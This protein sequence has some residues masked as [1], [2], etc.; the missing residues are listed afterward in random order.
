[1]E[2]RPATKAEFGDWSRAA[3]R[4]FHREFTDADRERYDR[5]DEP[6]R[7]LAWFDGG[8]IVATTGAFTRELTIPGGAIP[9]AAVTAV[10][11]VPTHRRRGLLTS[12]MRRQLD[13]LR[14]RGDAVAILWASEG[15]IYGRYGYRIAARAATLAARRP[16]ARLAPAPAAGEPL[17]AGP[18]GE[19]VEAMRAVYEGV[20][21]Q[22]PGLLDRPG[23]WW[24]DRLHDPESDR[25]GAQPLQAVIADG[26]YALYAVRPNEDEESGP[27]GEVRVRELVAATPDAH[28]RLWSFLL[29]QDLTRTTTWELAPADEPLWLRLGDPVAVRLTL[30][31]GLWL[32]LV[33]VAAALAA[34]S[35]ARDPDVVLAV[36]DG[37]CDWNAGRYRLTG[38]GCERTDAA[39]D[40]ELDVTDLAAAYLGAT[41]LLT[42]A[43]AGRV[44]ELTPGALART[45]AAFRGDVEPWCPETF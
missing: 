44:R 3:M 21:L 45:S 30:N 12:M 7:S 8:S 17:I 20:R 39:A 27:A 40:L 15:S 13:D 19:H 4:A 25:G 32:R 16:S 37:Y 10:A 42:M 5:I 14:E 18:A 22:R 34:R 28:A 23:P 41:T 6:E 11:V 1:M 31:D 9:C 2:L 43:A 29:D 33:D 35:Y 38:D 26:G 36:S 24:G